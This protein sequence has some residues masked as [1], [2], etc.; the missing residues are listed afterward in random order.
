MENKPC[1]TVI[2]LT[3]NQEKYIAKAL[4]GFVSQKANSP[5]KVIVHDD[6]S[7][8]KTPEI[9]QEYAKRYPELIM[10]IL[11]K[12]NLYS[13][14][15]D[16]LMTVLRPLIDTKYVAFCEGDDY[17][18]DDNKVQLQLDYME[19][20]DDC[21]ACVHNSS[22]IDEKGL[23]LQRFI[24][25][26]SQDCDLSA[27]TIIKSAGGGLFQTSSVFLR[28]SVLFEKPD[29]F[30]IK[31]I[32][33]YPLAIYLSSRGRVHYL[34]RVMSCY[35]VNS[36]GSWSLKLKK[37][38]KSR[39]AFFSDAISGLNAMNAYTNRRYDSAFKY[40][41][42][43]FTFSRSGSFKKILLALFD[44]DYRKILESHYLARKQ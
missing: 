14:G 5:F 4:D 11:E 23:S 41:I 39:K 20:N 3:Y 30:A 28:S 37:D 36:I 25:N 10:P 27:E 31:G 19:N 12:E 17:W 6:A 26:E 13:K 35:R 32:G 21:V 29:C 18:C 24:N 43:E 38:K 44:S 40:A 16:I 1:L 34:S 33:D 42:K 15:F 8:D 7:T 2:C 22:L 9:I